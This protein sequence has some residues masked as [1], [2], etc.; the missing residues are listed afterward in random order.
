MSGLSSDE[1]LRF[2]W[3]MPG[4]NG[5][6][7]E[8]AV[9]GRFYRVENGATLGEPVVRADMNGATGRQLLLSGGVKERVE[10]R[11]HQKTIPPHQNVILKV[12]SDG[13]N[14]FKPSR[15][16]EI[17]SKVHLTLSPDA[18]TAPAPDVRCSRKGHS[19]ALILPTE[20]LFGINADGRESKANHP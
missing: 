11:V 3:R 5:I 19:A 13:G 2:E 14:Q 20:A 7:A 6:E 1:R 17:L 16:D 10:I 9:F 12:Y 4:N 15:T 18:Q 8:R